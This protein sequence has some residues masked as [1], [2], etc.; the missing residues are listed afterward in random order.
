MATEEES[1][2]Q[3]YAPWSVACA[4]VNGTLHPFTYRQ[5]NWTPWSMKTKMR[6]ER[7]KEGLVVGVVIRTWEELDGA[8]GVDKI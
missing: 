3:G 1:F 2:F 6:W 8:V 7:E 4:P 5:H